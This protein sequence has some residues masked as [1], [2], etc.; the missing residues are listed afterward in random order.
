MRDHRRPRT[1]GR[2]SACSSRGRGAGARRRAPRPRDRRRRPAARRPRAAA[3]DARRC[4]GRLA[5]DSRSRAARCARGARHARAD[6]RRAI[7]LAARNIARVAG[8]QVPR[9]SSSE[10]APGVRSSSACSRSTRVGCY[11]PGG[12]Y[13]AAL[14]AADDRDAGARRR[15]AR[16]HRRL[17]AARRRSCWRA[18]LEAGATR[19]APRSAARRPSPRSRTARPRIPR[20]DKIVGPGN[21]W[22][23]AAKALV[24]ARLRDRPAR[25]ARARSWSCVGQRATRTGSPPISSRRPSTIRGARDPRHAEPALAARSRAKSTRAAAG[26]RPGAQSLAAQRRASSFA[27]TARGAID[28][29][30]RLAPE[31]LV[32]T[33]S[34]SDADRIHAAGTIFVGPWSAQAAA[35]TPPDR[36]TCCRPAA[37]RV[38]AAASAPADFVRVVHRADADPRAD[39]AASAPPAIALADAE[40]PDGPRAIRSGIRGRATHE[41][42]PTNAAEPTTGLRLHLN[43]NTAGCSPA[44]SRRFARSNARTSRS[45]P[46][47]PRSRRVAE[48]WFGVAA[49]G[50]SSRTASTKACTSAAARAAARR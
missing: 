42:R 16:D 23:A 6:V 21:A 41:L 39:S 28:V 10:V 1:H 30:N 44:C 7:R 48:R 36:I 27:Q 18:A 35:T 15:R 22:V 43:E 49:G 34:A 32:V 45:I 46:T 29:V 37:P 8:R 19:V 33:T 12:R 26:D 14:D 4:D 9:P 3:L 11:V 31:H 47:T 5:A 13:P 40:G 50:C 2:W 38:S 17:P 24:S 25:R 20:V